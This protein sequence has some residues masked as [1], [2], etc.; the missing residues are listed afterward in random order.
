MTHDIEWSV[1]HK[2]RYGKCRACGVEVDSQ[3]F[4]NKNGDYVPG[5]LFDSKLALTREPGACVPKTKKR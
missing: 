5:Y 2:G 3:A 1:A 4:R